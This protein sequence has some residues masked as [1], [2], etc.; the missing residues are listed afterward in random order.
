MVVGRHGDRLRAAR[1]DVLRRWRRSR[2]GRSGAGVGV[3]RGQIGEHRADRPADN[4]LS[5]VHPVGPDIG[6]RA[7]VRPAVG[8]DAPVVVVGLEEPVLGVGAGHAQ[9][10][11]DVAAADPCGARDRAGKTGRCN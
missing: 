7:E 9:D 8:L 2:P 4:E 3:E 1:L 10:A 5:Q 6:D 11:P